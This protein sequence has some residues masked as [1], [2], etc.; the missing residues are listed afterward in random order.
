[1]KIIFSRKGFDS[2]TGQVASPILP[3][4]ELFSLPI[5]ESKPDDRSPRYEQIMRGNYALGAIVNDL[6]KGNIKPNDLAHLDPDLNFSSISRPKNWKPIFG[7]AGVAESHLQKMGVKAGDIF[8]FFRWFRE[9]EEIEGKY[10]YV[11]GAPDL[12]I[13][14]GWLQIEQRISVD[15]LS[16]IPAWALE[17]PHCKLNKYSQLDSIYIAT[18]KINLP[19]VV[20]DKPG[21]GT[22]KRFSPAL[23][24]T[25]LDSS[26]RSIWQ[27]PTWFYPDGKKSTLSYHKSFKRWILDND[28]V[29]LSTVGRG[30][31]FVLDCEDYPESLNWLCNLLLKCD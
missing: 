26:K 14:F 21:A 15:D 7:Q 17:H 25:A 11:F 12:H 22:F 8:I 31:E 3:S 20:I 10:R 13:L 18:D 27:L 2:A 16:Q 30:Q 24:L 9:I 1:M 6:T 23:R 5:P 29:L 19:N 4:G 28:R